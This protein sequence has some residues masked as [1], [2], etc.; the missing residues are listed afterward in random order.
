[1]CRT[2]NGGGKKG[3]GCLRMRRLLQA[4]HR[5]KTA[6]QTGVGLITGVIEQTPVVLQRLSDKSDWSDVSDLPAGS[7]RALSLYRQVPP[8][9]PPR[10]K[11]AFAREPV[12]LGSRQRSVE[13]VI[14]FSADSCQLF[15]FTWGWG[16]QGYFFIAGGVFKR[17]FAAVEC[18]TGKYQGFP[19]CIS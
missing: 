12:S 4:L 18:L 14:L 11:Q 7:R 16:L 15:H 17:Y 5:P 1:M 3:D 2:G 19:V 6:R 10:V 9:S 8:Q 13:I